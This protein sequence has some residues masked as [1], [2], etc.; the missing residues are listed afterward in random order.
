MVRADKIA[1]SG[2]MHRPMFGM[3]MGSV[4]LNRGGAGAGSSY[5]SIDNFENTTGLTIPVGSGLGKKLESLI[6]KPLVKKPK[7]INFDM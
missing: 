1:V 5:T 2:R 3:G 6:V 7:N 4:L